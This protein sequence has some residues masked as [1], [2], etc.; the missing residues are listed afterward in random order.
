M[1]PLLPLVFF[2]VFIGIY[3]VQI[4]KLRLELQYSSRY[5]YEMLKSEVDRLSLKGI[6]CVSYASLECFTSSLSERIAVL[7]ER[8]KK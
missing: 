4:S 7:E 5:E 8:T 3:L 1:L 2:C 6:D